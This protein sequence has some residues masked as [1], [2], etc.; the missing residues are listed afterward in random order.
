MIFGFFGIIYIGHT[1]L[2]LLVTVFQALA[3]RE[4]AALGSKPRME[5]KL[6]GYFLL[7]W[8][9]FLTSIFLMYG[10]LLMEHLLIGMFNGRNVWME[11]IYRHHGFITFAMLIIGIISFVLSLKKGFYKYQFKQLGWCMAII[12]MLS[13]QLPSSST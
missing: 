2:C 10:Q 13:T 6:P 8:H 11:F 3:F 5:K 1:A 7:H 12:I 9:F 4:I